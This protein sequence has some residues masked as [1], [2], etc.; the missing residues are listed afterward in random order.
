MPKNPAGK[1]NL[2]PGHI[3]QFVYDPDNDRIRVDAAVT[4]TFTDQEVII[5]HEDDSIR[6]GDGT[7]LVTTTPGPGGSIGLDV[8][9][10]NP[11]QTEVSLTGLSL[12]IETTAVTVTDV[13]TPLPATALTDR[14]GMTVKVVGPETVYIGNS[15]VTVANG[16]PLLQGESFNIDIRDNPSV[17]LYG[18]CAAGKTCAVRIFEV[19]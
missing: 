14:N 15:S 16:F 3:A 19:A 8:N 4:A 1:S 7:D 2:G 13:A 10:V 6:L 12:D 18:I 5:S 17:Q 9:I 11:I